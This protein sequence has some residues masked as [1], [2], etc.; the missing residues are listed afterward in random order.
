MRLALDLDAGAVEP[1]DTLAGRV[2]VVE[3]G[4]SRSLT[5]T[6]NLR[7][8]SPGYVVPAFESRSLL[9]EGDLATGQTIEFRCAVPKGAPPSVKGKHGELFWELDV[10]SDERGL[11]TRA[12]RGFAVVA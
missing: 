5:L 2:L 4:A 3:G 8:R 9:H 11:D 10:V 6:V 12:S 7:E 1:G